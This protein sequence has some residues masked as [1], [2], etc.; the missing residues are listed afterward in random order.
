MASSTKEEITMATATQLDRPT[1]DR[2]ILDQPI[3][4]RCGELVLSPGVKTLIRH[5]R[6]D[7]KPHFLSHLSGDWGDAAIEQWAANERA[8]LDG[9]QLSSSYQLT[10]KITLS[11]TT[12]PDRS[13]TTITLEG[14]G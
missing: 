2:L 1:P 6:I 4:F 11:I 8:L 10:A 5:R 12:E 14:E 9:G 3:R 13:L 7:P